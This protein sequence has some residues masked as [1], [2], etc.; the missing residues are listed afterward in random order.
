MI[1][2]RVRRIVEN[3]P[4]ITPGAPARLRARSI[5]EVRSPIGRMAVQAPFSRSPTSLEVPRRLPASRNRLV[6][7]V[8]TNFHQVQRRVAYIV[9]TA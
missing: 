9:R 7:L 8:I 6:P 1:E 2:E 5:F 3:A 4:T